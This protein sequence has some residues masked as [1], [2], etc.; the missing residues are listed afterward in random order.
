MSPLLIPS[1][2]FL[3]HYN[4]Y[5]R[6]PQPEQLWAQ[7]PNITTTVRDTIKPTNTNDGRSLF[8]FSMHI[9][10]KH[11]V[12]GG[13]HILTLVRTSKNLAIRPPSTAPPKF[14]HLYRKIN[15]RN[16]TMYVSKMIVLNCVPSFCPLVL[17]PPPFQF[18]NLTNDSTAD[19]LTL[20]RWYSRFPR[21]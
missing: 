5:V 17:P 1:S 20:G 15:L 18:G 12:V 4:R 3:N 14:R 11:P 7:R 8:L 6:E 13:V 10:L 19:T 2:L 21:F 16:R 9:R